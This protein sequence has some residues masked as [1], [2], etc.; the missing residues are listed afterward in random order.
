M[1]EDFAVGAVEVVEELHTAVADHLALAS[2]QTPREVTQP[3]ER[4][5]SLPLW[6]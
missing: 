4:H 5:W 3:P 1:G 6:L 2:P